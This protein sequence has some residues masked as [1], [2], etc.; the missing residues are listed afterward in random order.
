V[1]DLLVCKYEDT[2]FVAN[3]QEERTKAKEKQGAKRK[4]SIPTWKGKG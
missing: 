3:Q 4:S 2:V 1:C